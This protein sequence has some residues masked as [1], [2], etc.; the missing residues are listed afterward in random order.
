VGSQSVI[1]WAVTIVQI[2]LDHHLFDS[3]LFYLMLLY[4]ICLTL[5]V[6]L[7]LLFNL[8]CNY[9]NYCYKN[10]YYSSFQLFHTILIPFNSFKDFNIPIHIPVII[11]SFFIFMFSYSHRLV[12]HV[13]RVQ[14]C[15]VPKR[16][17]GPPSEAGV[18]YEEKHTRAYCERYHNPC[19]R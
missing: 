12:T 19:Y 16:V 6:L 7:Y 3:I 14:R 1:Y 15:F 5:Y 10:Y 11:F 4:F 18:R 13:L 2:I 8:Y 17:V 9:Y